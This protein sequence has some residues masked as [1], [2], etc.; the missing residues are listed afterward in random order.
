M[1]R[2]EIHQPPVRRAPAPAPQIDEV[3]EVE[4]VLG[5]GDQSEAEVLETEDTLP[6]DKAGE[7][8]EELVVNGDE[9]VVEEATTASV[10]EPELEPADVPV[11]T[12][13]AS[14]GSKK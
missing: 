8:S 5:G 2:G 13:P 6:V 11:V 7:D 10:L 4:E 14:K 12:P 9:S 1:K 3:P